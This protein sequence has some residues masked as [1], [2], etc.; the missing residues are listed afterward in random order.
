MATQ[1]IIHLFSQNNT[2]FMT[3]LYITRRLP[4]RGLS[5]N[6]KQKLGVM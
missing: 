3:K 1:D 5:L 2:D 6:F 4:F